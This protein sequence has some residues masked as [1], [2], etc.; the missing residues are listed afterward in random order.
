MEFDTRISHS[1]PTEVELD[2]PAYR[3]D[4]DA[5][6]RQISSH[7]PIVPL[8]LPE[9][10][11]VWA[12]T[13]YREGM[14]VLRDPRFV[15]SSDDLPP[16]LRAFGGRRYTEDLMAVEGRHMN[17]APVRDHTRLR[18]P[19]AK[20]F[21]ARRIRH[22]E[23]FITRTAEGLLRPLADVA[24]FDLV[25][26]FCRPLA[27]QVLGEIMGL[28]VGLRGDASRLIGMLGSRNH[29]LTPRMR[30]T[31]TDLVDLL[32]DVLREQP[33]PGSVIAT[34][35]NEHAAGRM[36]KREMVSTL[37]FV[38]GAGTVSTQSTIGYGTVVLCRHPAQRRQL[39]I[40]ENHA[41]AVI[42][43]LWRYHSPFPFSTWRF[44]A[45]DVEI[46]GRVIPTGCPVLVLLASANRDPDIHDDPDTFC[47][48]RPT[49]AA[50]LT[51]G[52]G[53]HYCI[54][55]HLARS[56]ARIA[57]TTLFTLLPTITL[58]TA[59]E[60]LAWQGMLHDRTLAALPLRQE[61]RL[62]T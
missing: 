41:E 24:G 40:D 61:S 38:L 43:E 13:R 33:A 49:A 15:K 57:L 37:I 6:Y 26:E 5:A 11:R 36:S 7:A 60:A 8:V 35:H 30:Q 28:P 48:Y 47:P 42:E 23:P 56:E 9:G 18:R 46:A 32:R 55:A 19:V 52:H 1:R 31:Y 17:N 59:P 62:P 22:H 27:S 51:F 45:E 50:Q 39:L 29:P 16:P 20:H 21:S 4:A 53:P 54:G 44:A 34:L 25:S 12:A 3:D 14:Q 10:L 58:D 2:T